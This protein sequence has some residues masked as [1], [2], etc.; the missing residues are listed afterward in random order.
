MLAQRVI[1]GTIAGEGAIRLV[2]ALVAPIEDNVVRI[3]IGAIY[4]VAATAG[5]LVC[6][7]DAQ[8]DERER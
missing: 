6:R 2:L 4:L 7:W 1:A 3:V 8:Q 5:F